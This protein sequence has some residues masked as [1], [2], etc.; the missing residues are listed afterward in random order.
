MSVLY[1]PI[2]KKKKKGLKL[3]KYQDIKIYK[4]S[5]KVYKK[6]LKEV[7]LLRDSKHS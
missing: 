6:K 4:Q 5:P 7:K 3:C 2:I 1:P